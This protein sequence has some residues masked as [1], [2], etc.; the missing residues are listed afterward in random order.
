[1]GSDDAEGEGRV[2]GIA[3]M[4]LVDNTG[5]MDNLR[6]SVIDPL[7]IGFR[8]GGIVTV[9]RLFVD[10]EPNSFDLRLIERSE[11]AEIVNGVLTQDSVKINVT[12]TVTLEGTGVLSGQVPEDPQEFDTDTQTDVDIQLTITDSTLTAE[13]PVD[14][15]ESFDLSGVD[16]D[17]IVTG[18][19]VASGPLQLAQTSNVASVLITVDPLSRTDVEEVLPFSFSLQQN[20]PNPFA[21]STTIR[22]SIPR[23][24]QVVLR[25]YDTLGREVATLV[26]GV[27]MMGV[28]EVVFNAQ[29]LPSGMYLYRLEA[30]TFSDS[31]T[32]L[33]VR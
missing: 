3:T 2:G 30:D 14:L 29:S 9:G 13:V 26:D 5:H 28:H 23:A 18:S 7:E 33:L 10:A 19:L 32:L 31:K 27:K 20:Y 4:Y 25:V 17:M 12:G 8:F 15:Q 16:A 6:L 24:E 21:T 22:Y 11:P 1:M